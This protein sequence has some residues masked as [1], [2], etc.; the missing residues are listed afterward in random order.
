MNERDPAYLQH[1]LDS[2]DRIRRYTRDVDEDRFVRD[3]MRQDAVIRQISI[4]GEAVAKLSPEV[5]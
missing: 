5:E 2:I 1:I 3:E 4:I